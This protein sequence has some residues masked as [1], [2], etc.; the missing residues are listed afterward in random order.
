[1][2]LAL[3]LRECLPAG[4]IN[5]EMPMAELQDRV[6]R[7]FGVPESGAPQLLQF[8]TNFLAIEFLEF[9]YGHGGVCRWIQIGIHISVV[10]N[11]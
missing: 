8:F 4:R 2:Q 7:S 1:M 10:R 11:Q 9:E 3:G 6:A 5:P